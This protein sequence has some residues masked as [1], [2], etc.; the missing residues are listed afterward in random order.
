MNNYIEACV[1]FKFDLE[2]M[3]PVVSTTY[4]SIPFTK[5]RSDI[6]A[7]TILTNE[8]IDHFNNCLDFLE[9]STYP[10]NKFRSVHIVSST[11]EENKHYIEMVNTEDPN[12]NK[13]RIFINYKPE[14]FTN[15]WT[16][17]LSMIPSLSLPIEINYLAESP[18]RKTTFNLS[19]PQSKKKNS[20]VGILFNTSTILNCF[21][22]GF[23]YH[24][25]QNRTTRQTLI[26]Y[27]FRSSGGIIFYGLLYSI[28]GSLISNIC[29]Y[30]SNITLNSVLGYINYSMFTNIPK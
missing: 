23:L 24:Y 27:P 7:S 20:I 17:A 28:A 21:V 1:M 4:A 19:T 11:F 3:V 22:Y 10:L 13:H 16:Q 18:N 2:D 15:K 30:Y 29:P 9:N 6:N 14:L 12:D 5:A 25:G 8:Q 26:E